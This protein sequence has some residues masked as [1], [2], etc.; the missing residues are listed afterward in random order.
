MQGIHLND[1]HVHFDHP[2]GITIAVDGVTQQVPPRSFV[3]IVG[4]SG[5]GKSTLLAVIAGLQPATSGSVDVNGR[6]VTGPDRDIGV[7]FQEDST[8]PWR[9]VRENVEFAMQM[10][11]VSKGERAAK[12]AAAIEL[13]GLKGFEHSYP[14]TLSGGM[15]QRV[16]LARTLALQPGVVLMDEPFAALDQQTRIFL[17]AEV[18]RIWEQTHQTVLFVT[19]DISEAILLSQQ[20]WVMSYRPGHVI[21]VIDID[22][23]DERDASIVS[24]PRFNELHNRVWA[25]LQKESMRGFQDVETA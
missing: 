16:A 13:V 15:R 25:S 19:H 20:I 9:N 18:R 2:S 12:A 17:G 24:S 21:D 7:V 1:V 10:A 14:A 3:S 23:P 6:R 4:P 22:L 11:G 8:L 5:C